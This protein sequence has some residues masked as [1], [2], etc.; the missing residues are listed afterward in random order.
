MSILHF[1]LNIWEQ[2]GG[3]IAVFTFWAIVGCACITLQRTIWA[4]YKTTRL[5]LRGESA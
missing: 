3:T 4:A 1:L 2:H 5:W